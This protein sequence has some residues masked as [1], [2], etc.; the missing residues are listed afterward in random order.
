MSW[1][2]DEVRANLKVRELDRNARVKYVALAHPSRRWC[3]YRNATFTV[4]GTTPIHAEALVASAPSWWEALEQFHAWKR[5]PRHEALF[6]DRHLKG[7]DLHTML[8]GVS[9]A[10]SEKQAA[11]RKHAR[12]VHSEGLV[13]QAH[14]RATRLGY[15]D[16]VR[17]FFRGLTS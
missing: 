3:V 13:K 17:G 12:E 16:K 2:G 9:A 6:L 8:P 4:D 5:D 11:W 14:H 15:I 7:E 10:L 1:N